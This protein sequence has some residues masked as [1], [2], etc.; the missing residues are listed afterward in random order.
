ML[1]GT[2]SRSHCRRPL[3]PAPRRPACRTGG[4]AEILALLQR[5]RHP[6]LLEAELAKRRL[7]RSVLGVGWHVA[8][9]VGAGALLRIP[10][11][12]GPLLRAAKR[13]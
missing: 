5:R 11:A 9:M 4:R 7:Q 6:E 2:C 8:D 13:P 3:P 10:T 1:A 12:V